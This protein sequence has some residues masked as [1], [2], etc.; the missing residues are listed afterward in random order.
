M[1]CV[2]HFT[3]VKAIQ[4]HQQDQSVGFALFDQTNQPW[5][6]MPLPAEVQTLGFTLG[7]SP[8]SAENLDNPMLGQ[9]FL[10]QPPQAICCL[11]AVTLKHKIGLGFS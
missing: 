1:H 6:E 9:A 10:S 8:C 2:A 5:R 3:M 4:S 7:I 11:N